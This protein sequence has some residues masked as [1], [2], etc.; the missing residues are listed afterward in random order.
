MAG[1]VGAAEPGAPVKVRRAF[2]ACRSRC[3][4]VRS[5]AWSW[6]R[7]DWQRIVACMW[8]AKGWRQSGRQSG[9]GQVVWLC[10]RLHYPCLHM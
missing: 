6:P 4:R 9:G 2:A 8:A 7:N 1:G 5:P 10:V 3:T